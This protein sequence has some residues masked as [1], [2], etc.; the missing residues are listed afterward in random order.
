MI[1]YGRVQN[2]PWFATGMNGLI[3]M[4]ARWRVL[5]PEKQPGAAREIPRP[6]WGGD[7]RAAWFTGANTSLVTQ[8]KTSA[9]GRMFFAKKS[10]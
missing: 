3:V 7:R 2:A 6:L 9:I 4:Y 1:I 8:Y 10:F 5:I